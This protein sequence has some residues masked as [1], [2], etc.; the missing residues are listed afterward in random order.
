M[1]HSHLVVNQPS[2]QGSVL[3]R[4]VSDSRLGQI[5]F[6]VHRW[7]VLG[8]AIAETQ[9]ELAA[10][11]AAHRDT[12]FSF[13]VGKDIER[14]SGKS[15]LELCW[16]T[17]ERVQYLNRR[18]ALYQNPEDRIERSGKFYYFLIRLAGI[19]GGDVAASKFMD[20]PRNDKRVREHECPNYLIGSFAD[21]SPEQITEFERTFSPETKAQFASYCEY[22]ALEKA[23]AKRRGSKSKW[24][25]SS[26]EE[27]AHFSNSLASGVSV[28]DNWKDC[29]VITQ[30]QISKA[31]ERLPNFTRPAERPITFDSTLDKHVTGR[32]GKVYLYPF[33]KPGVLAKKN[34]CPV[35]KEYVAKWHNTTKGLACKEH[36]ARR[37]EREAAHLAKMR[38]TPSSPFAATVISRPLAFAKNG[39]R[40]CVEDRMIE[41]LDRQAGRSQHFIEAEHKPRKSKR[42]YVRHGAGSTVNFVR[43]QDLKLATNV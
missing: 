31:D 29:T 9:A 8:R 33:R 18:I 15:A 27:L 42:H 30:S 11:R 1:A 38:Y 7:M 5:I 19:A 3:G 26:P 20:D 40:N 35:C 13:T 34:W 39:S 21:V 32:Y 37:A 28:G 24:H 4:I 22:R 36:I 43:Q 2:H 23:T 17:L 16:E 6:A 12:L 10:E 25:V 41:R 14:S